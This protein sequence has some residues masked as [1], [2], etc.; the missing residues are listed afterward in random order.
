M[1]LDTIP[2]DWEDRAALYIAYLVEE[3]GLQSSTIK[4]YLSAIKKVLSDDNY[5]W[6]DSKILMGTYM[7]A[8]KNINDKIKPRLPIHRG[9]LELILFE[10]KRC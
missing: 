6:D 3:Q 8:C 1:K 5:P 10:T 9:L 7:K 2:H 4:S